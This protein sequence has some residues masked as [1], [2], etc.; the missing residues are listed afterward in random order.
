MKAQPLADTVPISASQTPTQKWVRPDPAGD[1]AAWFGGSCVVRSSG[2]PRIL[3][4]GTTADFDEFEFDTSPRDLGLHFGP[5]KTANSFARGDG[6]RVVPVVLRI[7]KP[8]VLRDT[9]GHGGA[10]VADTQYQLR[11]LGIGEDFKHRAVAGCLRDGDALTAWRM[12]RDMIECAGY[13][14]VTYLNTGRLEGGGIC[15]VAFR[16]Q[17]VR[18][19][20]HP[21]LHGMGLRHVY[22][23]DVHDA[24]FLDPAEVDPDDPDVDVGDG[25]ADEDIDGRMAIERCRA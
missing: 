14:G 12:V 19:V 3:Y 13:D 8:L 22:G 5:A 7:C 4:H 17:Q 18:S 2:A 21:S 6:G 1:F 24:Y 11:T 23:W 9:F 20:F 15:Y 16:P 25:E 10:N